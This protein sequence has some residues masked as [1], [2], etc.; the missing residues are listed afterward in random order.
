MNTF[1]IVLTVAVV[2][3]IMASVI[4]S[5][6]QKLK[7][8]KKVVKELERELANKEINI[9]YLVKH[10]QELANILQNNAEIQ[11]KI[12]EA[13]TDEEINNIVAAVVAA[14]NDRVQD[15]KAKGK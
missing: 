5:L 10:S 11:N 3:L 7:D 15:N 12:D 13:K 8:L 2:F 1:S 6:F 4:Y 14:N 9:S